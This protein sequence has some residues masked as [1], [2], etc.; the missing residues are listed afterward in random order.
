MQVLQMQ[1]HLPY[2][3]W[4]CFFF[5]RANETLWY[6]DVSNNNIQK[7]HIEQPEVKAKDLKCKEINKNKYI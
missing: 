5:D 4:T 2:V 6:V 3:K 7:S 1:F